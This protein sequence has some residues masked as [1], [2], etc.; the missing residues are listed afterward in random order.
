MSE[1]NYKRPVQGL[2][3]AAGQYDARLNKPHRIDQ[4]SEQCASEMPWQNPRDLIDQ[5]I[6]RL[7]RDVNELHALRRALP[8]EMLPQAERVLVRILERAFRR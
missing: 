4:C 3:A 6:D 1:E 8:S 2:G 7:N 5:E